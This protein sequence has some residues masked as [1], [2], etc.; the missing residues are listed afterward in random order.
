MFLERFVLGLERFVLGI[1]AICPWTGHLDYMRSDDM[2]T[3]N[4]S[5]FLKQVS[6]AHPKK[7]IIMVLDGASTHKSKDLI[8]PSNVS[9]IILPPYSPEL[10]PTERLWD[11]LRKLYFANRYFDTLQEAMEQVDMGLADMKRGR[12]ALKR[13]TNWDWINAISKTT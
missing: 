5:R 6:K 4:M 1:G 9:L 12:T 10:N 11:R 3:P 2:K 7:F 8:I 13:L